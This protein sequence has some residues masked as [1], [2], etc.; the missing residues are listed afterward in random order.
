M[1]EFE[2]I[3]LEIMSFIAEHR[4]GISVD[5]AIIELMERGELEE[6]PPAIPAVPQEACAAEKEQAELEQGMD[7]WLE[8]EE[9][10]R[11]D[12]EMN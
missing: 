10:T 7:A 11:N 8:T 2:P 5:D 4:G 9:S 1:Q 6:Q 3:R 12:V